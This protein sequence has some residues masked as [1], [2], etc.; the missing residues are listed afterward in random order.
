MNRP[1]LITRHRPTMSWLS[2]LL[3]VWLRR[4]CLS[5]AKRTLS[6]P[7]EVVPSFL[8]CTMCWLS[9]FGCCP[10]I[11]LDGKWFLCPQWKRVRLPKAAPIS[12]RVIPSPMYV[13]SHGL[14][15]RLVLSSCP[16]EADTHLVHVGGTD[17][18]Y[19]IQQPSRIMQSTTTN[20]LVQLSR[21]SSEL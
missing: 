7:K 2:R 12:H 4:L 10:L 20:T 17:L 9:R 1:L 18:E 14:F 11:G 19:L 5:L 3:T 16:K 15:R 6:V 8:H 21:Y 13:D